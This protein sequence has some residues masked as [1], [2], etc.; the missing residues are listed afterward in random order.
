MPQKPKKNM[1]PPFSQWTL[2]ANAVVTEPYKLTLNSTGTFQSTS[3]D[4]DILPNTTYT[5][6]INTSNGSG[7]AEFGTLDASNTFTSIT[8]TVGSSGNLTRTFTTPANAVKLRCITSNTTTGTFTFDKPQL[9]LGSVATSFENYKLISDV[10]ILPLVPKKN[11]LLPLTDIGWIRD[12]GNSFLTINGDYDFTSSGGNNPIRRTLD[13]VGGQPYTLSLISNGGTYEIA[14]YDAASSLIT[15][16][17]ATNNLNSFVTP[18]NCVKVRIS[19]Y[20]GSTSTMNFRNLQ[21]EKGAVATPFESYQLVP[22]VKPI[23]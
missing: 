19:F 14:Y 21:L 17:A 3:I 15:F 4:F 1:L 6:S 18:S 22:D 8:N 7:Y 2:N 20:S 11:L 13:V 9:E 10:K 16:V 12:F 5:A 23:V